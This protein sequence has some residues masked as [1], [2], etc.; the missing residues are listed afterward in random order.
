M[1]QSA[2]LTVV[3]GDDDEAFRE[4]LVDVLAADDR[5]EVVGSTASG[6]EVRRLSSMWLAICF[7][8]GDIGSRRLAPISSSADA[9]GCASGR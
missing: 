4:A 5:F 3:V 7:R 1:S 8:I 6:A 2:P 9:A